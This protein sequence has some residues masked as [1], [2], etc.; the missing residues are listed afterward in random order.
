[1]SW[2]IG[3]DIGGAF[4]DLYAVNPETGETNWTKVESTP[5]EFENGV[6]DGVKQLEEKGISLEN[7]DQIIH[8][9]TVV[10]NTIITRSGSKVG[11]ITSKGYDI[12]DMQRGNRRDIFNFKY[13]KPEQFVDRHMTEWVD[14]RI[15]EDGSIHR[16]LDEKEVE[17]ATKSLIEKGAE[18]ISIGFINS[19][20]NPEHERKAKK[21]VERVCRENGIENP[22]LTISSDTTQEWREYE[23][24]NTAILNS[25]VQPTFVKYINKL[26][27]ALEEEGFDG[28]FYLTLASGGMATAKFSKDF[29]ITTVE[30]GPI[31]GIMGATSLGELLDEKD[32]I[33]IDGGSTTSKAGLAENLRPK[34]KTE[35]WIE[36]DK[37]NPGYPAK[38]PVVDIQEVGNGGTSILWADEAGNLQVGPDAAGARPGPACYDMGGEKPTLTD[39]YVVAGYLNPEYLLG[40]DLKIDKDL[41][42]S[43]LKEVADKVGLD[44]KDTAYGAIRVANNKSARLIRLISIRKGFDPRDFTMIAHGGSGPMMA[45]FIA[46]ELDIPETIVPAIPSGVFNPWGMIGLDIRHELV[47]TRDIVMGEDEESIKDINETFETLEGEIREAFESEDIGQEKVVI[48][49]RLDMKYEGQAHTLKITCPNGKI[50]VKEIQALKKEFHK[51]HNREYGFKLEDSPI[52]I[53]NFHDIGLIPIEPPIIEK[54]ENEATLEDSFLGEREV[55]NGEEGSMTPVYQK[56]KFPIGVEVEGPCIIDGKTATIIVPKEFKVKHDVYG[57]LRMK[58]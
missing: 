27:K 12:I 22:L 49:R 7:A 4:T 14:E 21:I 39:A 46:K 1:M 6:L 47:K 33:V 23:R 17:K 34:T 20:Q 16:P 8:G 28:T 32:I 54:Y 3:V 15:D 9:Q 5:P 58:H 31:S 36:Q 44:V 29:P 30:G 13:K 26:E 48:N 56:E 52:K 42:L 40:G 38:V 45:P 2:R 18:A 19:Y 24:F 41:A 25:Y 43:S 11:F 55:Y 57:N 35:Y 10:I 53:V 37:Y 50:T 51:T